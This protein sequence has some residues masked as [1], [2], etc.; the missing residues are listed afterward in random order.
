MFSSVSVLSKEVRQSTV[1]HCSTH[2]KKTVGLQNKIAPDAGK[3]KSNAKR[4]L[5]E[6]TFSNG[7]AKISQKEQRKG[8]AKKNA[9]FLVSMTTNPGNFVIHV[10]D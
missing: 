4:M 3:K 10:V 9:P 1:E 2:L 5:P 7:S 8:D 6:V